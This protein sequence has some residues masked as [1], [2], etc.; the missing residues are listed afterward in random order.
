M[1]AKTYPD[2]Y[3]LRSINQVPFTAIM[4]RVGT[5]PV[6]LDFLVPGFDL[7]IWKMRPCVR[8]PEDMELLQ[9]ALRTLDYAIETCDPG[10]MIYEFDGFS[11]FAF[12][13]KYRDAVLIEMGITEIV[14]G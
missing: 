4:R 2:F 13:A 14:P 9:A 12:H 3:Q 7:V 5:R 8:E 6:L 11:F 1:S 10:A